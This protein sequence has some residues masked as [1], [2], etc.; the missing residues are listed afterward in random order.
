M[1]SL[2]PTPPVQHY[3]YYVDKMLVPCLQFISHYPAQYAWDFGRQN[4]DI[5]KY[6]IAV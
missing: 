1:A 6:S 4:K 3:C 5:Q 2:T